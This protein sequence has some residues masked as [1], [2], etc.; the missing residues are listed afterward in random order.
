MSI[1]WCG[2]D[3]HHSCGPHGDNSWEDISF[4]GSYVHSYGSCDS[5]YDSISTKQ[6]LCEYMDCDPYTSDENSNSRKGS[7]EGESPGNK[8]GRNTRDGEGTSSG[9]KAPEPPP[10]SLPEAFED[11]TVPLLSGASHPLSKLSNGSIA[12]LWGPRTSAQWHEQMRTAA[13]GSI[14]LSYRWMPSAGLVH[15]PTSHWSQRNITLGSTP[16]KKRAFYGRPLLQAS[17]VQARPRKPTNSKETSK[18]KVL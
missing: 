6:R 11:G 8:D 14:S 13:A 9:L 1:S 7:G 2:E 17:R 5:N 10:K 18:I 16:I 4:C 12:T 15:A 3:S